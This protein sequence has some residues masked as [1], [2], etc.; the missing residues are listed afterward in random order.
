MDIVD[1][2]GRHDPHGANG[3]D[4]FHVGLT[5]HLD[6]HGHV[7]PVEPSMPGA[8]RDATLFRIVLGAA[9]E[10]VDIDRQHPTFRRRDGTHLQ[11]HSKR[12]G[13]P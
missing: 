4:R 13:A 6:D 1:A 7:T 3:P 2:A 10:P 8:S 11:L 12:P 9:G 5:V